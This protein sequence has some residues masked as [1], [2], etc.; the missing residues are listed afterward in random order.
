MWQCLLFISLSF[1]ILVFNFFLF[2]LCVGVPSQDRSQ[3]F[4]FLALRGSS[5]LRMESESENVFTAVWSRDLGFTSYG[6]HHMAY[7]LRTHTRSI[8]VLYLQSP[9]YS[10]QRKTPS[11]HLS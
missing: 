9:L 1:F 7:I 8:Q 5:V 10:S 11:L 3:G 2:S 6:V 4:F